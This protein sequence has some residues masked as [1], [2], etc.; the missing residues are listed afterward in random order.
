MPI[1]GG[2]MVRKKSQPSFFPARECQHNSW[3]LTGVENN[4][5]ESEVLNFLE[6]SRILAAESAAVQNSKTKDDRYQ[7]RKRPYRQDSSDI[8]NCYLEEVLSSSDSSLVAACVIKLHTKSHD[9]IASKFSIIKL[10]ER[11]FKLKSISSIDDMRELLMTQENQILLYDFVEDRYSFRLL[12]KH[13]S[14]EVSFSLSEPI[15]PDLQVFQ[16]SASLSK[17][18]ALFLCFSVD[19]RQECVVVK[20]YLNNAFA[21]DVDAAPRSKK[22]SQP[23]TVRKMIHFKVFL[24]HVFRFNDED[25]N[26]SNSDGNFFYILIRIL[27]P[28]I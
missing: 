28:L 26:I 24:N 20:E 11:R 27:T 18:S 22:K 7:S 12:S 25:M 4:S 23:L 5:C 1:L 17:L 14:T 16:A 2:A 19:Q 8:S 6:K 10:R 9:S 21:V 15:Y 13:N 3:S